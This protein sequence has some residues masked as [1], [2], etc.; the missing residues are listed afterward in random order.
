MPFDGFSL[1]LICCLVFCFRDLCF[2]N[3]VI[4]CICFLCYMVGL[5]FDLVLCGVLVLPGGGWC[6]MRPEYALLLFSGS[7]LIVAF[8]SYIWCGF[9]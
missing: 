2:V 8:C 4:A 7:D 3:S 5:T 6:L 9:R 1:R